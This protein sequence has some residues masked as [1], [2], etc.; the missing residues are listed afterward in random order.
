MWRFSISVVERERTSGEH[1][2]TGSFENGSS[3]F[4][5][6]LESIGH[7]FADWLTAVSLWV[8]LHTT[9]SSFRDIH[10]NCNVTQII[11]RSNYCMGHWHPSSFMSYPSQDTLSFYAWESSNVVW[12]RSSYGPKTRSK[13]IHEISLNEVYGAPQKGAFAILLFLIR[14]AKWLGYL[15]IR[16]QFFW[17][18][19]GEAQA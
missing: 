14:N 13:F 19:E 16:Q 6:C 2:N 17:Y 11:W 10:Q 4:V 8:S 18:G 1:R 7:R 12:S 3:L 5:D 9:L 15:L